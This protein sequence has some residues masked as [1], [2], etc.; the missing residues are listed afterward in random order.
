MN[1]SADLRSGASRVAFR[2]R[3]AGGRRSNSRC[4]W[5]Q[6]TREG[7]RRLSTNLAAADMN[8]GIPLWRNSSPKQE[9]QAIG[10][11]AMFFF[12]LLTLDCLAGEVIPPK[13]DAYFNDYA[14]I[15][16][17]PTARRL[18]KVLEDFEK[19]TSS[20]IVVAIFRKMQSDSSLEDYTHQV[21][22]AWEVGQKNKNNG[23]ILFIF[24]ED[25]RARIEVG[26]GLEGA[27]PDAVAK[28]ILDDE[29]TP[30]FKRGDY[31]GGLTA[32]VNAIL[33]ATRGEYQ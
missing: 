14:G 16:S 4:A 12:A 32:G 10:L 6:C 25:R 3:R 22:E 20:Q 19:T 30:R 26:Y 33:Q 21:F 28:R 24:V 31:A 18:N 11:L 27:L 7:E 8:P 1:R 9:L 23:A 29:V 5:S 17:N 2:L 15:V 13:P